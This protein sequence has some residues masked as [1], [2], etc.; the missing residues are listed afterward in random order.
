[1][2]AVGVDYTLARVLGNE[3]IEDG[4]FILSLEVPNSFL[5]AEPGQFVMLRTGTESD[6][7]LARPLSIYSVGPLGSVAQCDLLYKVAG[8]GT[9]ILSRRRPG[10]FLRVLGPV[11]REF[12][13]SRVLQKVVLVAGGAGIAPLSFLA[14]KL[15][16]I[17]GLELVF[18]YGARTKKAL[19]GL[20]RLRNLNIALKICTEDCSCGEGGVVTKK[21]AKDLRSQDFSGCAVFAC[22]PVPMLKSLYLLIKSSAMPV[23]VSIEERMACGIGACLGCAVKTR[24]G[25][26]RVCSEGPVFDMNEIL[27]DEC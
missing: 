12:D 26:Q 25:F 15:A 11:G 1:M 18:Y 24:S 3:E 27:W 20:N 13:L 22:G 4:F 8:R 16:E 19:V 5:L 17:E 9:A 23:Q 10:E 7:L 2:A 21:L 14:A 6:P